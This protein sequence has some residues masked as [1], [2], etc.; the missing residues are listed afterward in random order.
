M[1]YRDAPKGPTALRKLFWKE[2]APSSQLESVSIEEQKNAPVRDSQKDSCP[3]SG[4]QIHAAAR[5][6][7]D[8]NRSHRYLDQSSMGDCESC[9][10]ALHSYRSRHRDIIPEEDSPDHE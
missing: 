1:C 2:A 4:F 5:S 8:M 6:V 3:P 10:S 7:S 9:P